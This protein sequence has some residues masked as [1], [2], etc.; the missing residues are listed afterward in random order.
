MSSIVD[1]NLQVNTKIKMFNVQIK[2]E[3]NQPEVEKIPTSKLIA[4]SN[5]ITQQS[6]TTPSV[7]TNKA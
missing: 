2:K 1:M 7:E 3:D 5:K 6:I 4:S